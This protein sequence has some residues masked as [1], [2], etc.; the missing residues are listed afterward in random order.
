MTETVE[1]SY[2][3]LKKILEMHVDATKL[4]EKIPQMMDEG[5]FSEASQHIGAELEARVT[6]MNN[7]EKQDHVI[8]QVLEKI[9]NEEINSGE[10]LEDLERDILGE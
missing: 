10:S 2:D 9:S 7:A 3:T 6:E 8:R 4:L 5:R 1:L